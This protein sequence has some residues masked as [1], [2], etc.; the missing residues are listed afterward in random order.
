MG[1]MEASIREYEGAG[2][3]PEPAE[4]ANFKDIKGVWKD[5]KT[6]YNRD[7]NERLP[8]AERH[9]YLRAGAEQEKV[10]QQWD[11]AQG[12]PPVMDIQG[13]YLE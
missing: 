12:P 5:A 4:G 1:R 8:E 13:V 10:A 11:Q 7:F 6:T 3:E 2:A 9:Q